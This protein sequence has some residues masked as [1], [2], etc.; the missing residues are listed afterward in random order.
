MNTRIKSISF[1]ISPKKNNNQDFF[2]LNS[3]FEITFKEGIS[4][5]YSGSLSFYAD[6][7][8][9]TSDIQCQ[10]GRQ[11]SISVEITDTLKV[12]GCKFRQ[13]FFFFSECYLY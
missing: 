7:A 1:T 4:D 2:P 11:L 12:D 13:V 9:N 3:V 8:L 10:I 6:N 5:L